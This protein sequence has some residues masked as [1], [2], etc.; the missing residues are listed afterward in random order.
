MRRGREGAVEER[1]TEAH[2]LGVSLDGSDVVLMRERILTQLLS[3]TPFRYEV[4]SFQF[5]CI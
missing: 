2:A 3:C 4:I 5:V 1:R